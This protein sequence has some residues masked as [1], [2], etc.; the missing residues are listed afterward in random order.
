MG[1]RDATG[2]DEAATARPSTLVNGNVRVAG[3]RTSIRLEPAMWQALRAVAMREH[4]ALDALVT[5]INRRRLESS[6]TAAIRVYL[7]QY[8]RAAATEEGHR[9]ARH[10]A[11]ARAMK[12]GA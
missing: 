3:H 7:V 2:P 8:F 12:R 6:L 4:V 1:S 11:P 5:A 9:R 10:G